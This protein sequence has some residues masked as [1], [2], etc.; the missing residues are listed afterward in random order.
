VGL[1]DEIDVLKGTR[2]TTETC[3]FIRGG[4]A[5]FVPR[6][7]LCDEIDVLKGTRGTTETCGFIRGG[8]ASVVPRVDNLSV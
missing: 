4:L 3:G 5:S 6:V 1:C 7:G 2:G 8:L